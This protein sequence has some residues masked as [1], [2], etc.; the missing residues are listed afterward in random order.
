MTET[1]EITE[2]SYAEYRDEV[3]AAQS[4]MDYDD[5]RREMSRSNE[6]V[7]ELDKLP[8]IRHNWVDRGLVMSCEG[9]GHENHRSFK[10]LK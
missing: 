3:K 9:A 2:Q 6:S 8:K 1:P 4:A 7:F 10:R 5:I